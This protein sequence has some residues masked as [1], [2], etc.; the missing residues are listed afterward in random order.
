MITDKIRLHLTAG[1]LCCGVAAALTSCSDFLYDDSDQVIYADDHALDSDADTLWS[2]AG[3][4]NKL[5]VIADRTILLGEVRGDLVELTQHA[6]AD[7]RQIA[8]FEATN[9]EE[10]LAG[11]PRDYY[12]VINNCNF[13]IARADTALRNNRN[14]LI[15]QKEYAAVKAFRAW[16][17]LQLVMNYGRVP[18]ITDPIL[19]KADAEK[20]Y[21][22]YDIQQVCQYFIND[23]T[24]YADTEMPGYSVIRGT[25]SQLFYYPI[26]VLLGDL[27]LWSGQYRA[28]AE[29]YYKYISTR[30]GNNSVYPISTNAVRFLN[31]DAHWINISDSWSLSSFV[32]EASMSTGELITMIPGDS[33]PSEG[34]Y[35]ELRDLFNTNENNDYRASII[36]SQAIIDLSAA[37]KYCQYTTGG[38]FIIAPDGLSD[39]RSGDLRLQAIYKTQENAFVGGKRISSFSS[40]SKYATRNVHILRRAMVY[41]RMAEALNRA[42]FPRFAFLIL[43][44]GVNN[45]IIENDVIP[46]YPENADWLRTFNFP[47]NS[48]VIQ[49]TAGQAGENTIGLHSRGCGFTAYNN[50]YVLPDDSTLNEAARLQY[51]I[52]HVEDLIVDEE[53]LEFAFEG[54]RFYDLMRIALRRTD[55]AY[56]ASRVARRSG[57]TNTALL[58][59]LSDPANWYLKIDN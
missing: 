9:S 59:I 1:L 17:Y 10:G 31:N 18:F 37:Q 52:E 51:Q 54:H 8:N 22:Q 27:Y 13:F 5:Q 3:I 48:Y 43:K 19:T 33:I 2:V 56:L 42:G 47:N 44:Q 53:A 39:N 55:P 23:I 36:P 16:T 12:A 40:N 46:Y 29:N 50:T 28:A 45:S 26:Y 24:P 21:P 57:T 35:S 49:T 41:L 38:E 11:S 14:E 58:T 7:L 34:N 6:S 4:M 25:D 32:T 30:N 15:F 20:D